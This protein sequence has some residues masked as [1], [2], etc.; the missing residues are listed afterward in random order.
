[1]MSLGEWARRKH[2]QRRRLIETLADETFLYELHHPH[3]GDPLGG[4][5]DKIR[6]DMLLRGRGWEHEGDGAADS[7][8]RGEGAI[9]LTRYFTFEAEESLEG[10]PVRPR[11][12]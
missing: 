7:P 9:D 11:P 8:A 1:M 2:R 6:Q 5:V 4:A 12:S 3:D 10:L